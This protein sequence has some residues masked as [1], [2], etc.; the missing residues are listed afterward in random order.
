MILSEVRD[1]LFD[2][3]VPNVDN[4]VNVD[5]FNRYLNLVQERYINSGKW[6]GMMKEISVVA[7]GGYF[8]LPPRF[9][10]ALAIKNLD[11]ANPI[12]LNNRWYAY[13]YGRSVMNLDASVWSSYG[14]ATAI[15][16]GDGFTTFKDAPYAAYYLRFTYANAADAGMQVL[17]KGNDDTGAPIFTQL[18]PAA[19][20]GLT[21]TLATPI[22][23]T[24]QKFSGRI[25]FLQK[26]RS[27]GYLYLDA[28]DAAT[29]AVT[30]IGYYAPS[31]TT[32]SYHRYLSGC[33]TQAD[34]NVL[35][36]CK[37]RYT[38][39]VADS[40]EVVP[41]NAGALRCGL[42]RD[43]VRGTGRYG[44]TGPVSGGRFANA[45]GRG[46]RE[47]WRSAIFASHRSGAFQFASL[48]QGR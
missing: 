31:E 26:L 1:L 9:V 32:P 37:I 28:V 24:T 6:T 46:A 10:A 33:S 11:S 27:K 20:E 39:A 13:Y 16:M 38:P 2:V 43:Q 21:I 42:G 41:S 14:Y 25:Q 8:T 30:R 23:T 3:V 18:D 22:T 34:W 35:A 17:V 48:Y 44:T 7:S 29:G 47:P 4:Q 36:I 15:D 19:Y 40:D 12:Q 45:L 5:R